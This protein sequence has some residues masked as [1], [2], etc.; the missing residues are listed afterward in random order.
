MEDND[1]GDDSDGDGDANGDDDDSDGDGDGDGDGGD[2]DTGN[3]DIR[4]GAKME[5][6]VAANFTKPHL[7]RQP[8]IFIS[9][10]AFSLGNTKSI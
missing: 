9:N 10:D 7:R 6:N 2:G 8:S 5:D 1:D 4:S 3:G